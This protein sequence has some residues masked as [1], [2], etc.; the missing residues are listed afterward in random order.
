MALFKFYTVHIHTRYPLYNMLSLI[1]IEIMGLS[2]VIGE[3]GRNGC[4][5]R[6]AEINPKINIYMQF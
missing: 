5:D 3:Y 1:I 6:H 4:G 2:L